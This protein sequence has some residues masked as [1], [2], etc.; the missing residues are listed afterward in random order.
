MASQANQKKRSGPEGVIYGGESVWLVLDETGI[1]ELC[2]ENYRGSANTLNAETFRDLSNALDALDDTPNVKGLMVSSAKKNFIVGADLDEFTSLFR[3]S[4]PEILEILKGIYKI[5]SRMED[6]PMPTACAINGLALGGGFEI[7]LATDFRIMSTDA[8][9]GMPEVNFGI[10]PGYGATVRL[11]RLI[12]PDLAAEWI[13]SGKTQDAAAA[14]AAGAVDALVAPDLLRA[15][16]LDILGKCFNGTFDHRESRSRKT[17][18]VAMDDDELAYAFASSLG[19]IAAMGASLNTAPRVGIGIMQAHASLDRDQALEHEA[20]EVA[21]LA[22]SPVAQALIA[23]FHK[24][25]TLDRRAAT[26]CKGF[27]PPRAAAVVGAGVMGGGIAYQCAMK[28]IPVQL[29]DLDQDSLDRTLDGLSKAAAARVVKR[30]LEPLKMAAILNRINPTLTFAAFSQVDLVVE[31]VAENLAIKNSV[32]EEIEK[33]TPR[34]TIIVTNTST[35]SVSALAEQLERPQDFCGMHFFNPVQQ[36]PL[37]E[38]VRGDRTSDETVAKVV[39]FALA[40]GKKPVVVGDCPGFVVNRLLFGYFMAFFSLLSQGARIE[41]IDETLRAFGWPMGPGQLLDVI[42]LDVVQHALPVIINGYPDRMTTQSTDVVTGLFSAGRFGQKT[43]QGFYSYQ[44]DSGGR[45]RAAADEEVYQLFNVPSDGAAG[46]TDEEIIDR[47]MIPMCMEAARCVE[48]GIVETAADIDMS[49]VYG[50]AFPGPRGG[51]LSF[52][53]QM[54]VEVFCE[55]AASLGAHGAM[56][57]PTDQLR[58]MAA[59]G[60]TFFK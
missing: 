56:Y 9:V 2:F 19:Q 25:Q 46:L 50:A 58:E 59:S 3:R 31:A 16:T 7:C 52:I 22:K 49:M 28:G 18:P 34:G 33:V 24:D 53:D 12:G 60:S 26:I 57:L 38:I 32:I 36:M 39:A 20:T 1:A 5:I 15:A 43:G 55:R 27:T 54:G 42:G 14:M 10:V 40:L 6:L 21:R 45:Q 17:A 23:N 11:S 47:L 4:Y 37:V 13:A 35:L 44:T 30:R 8:Q 51:P 29:K 41:R 48:E